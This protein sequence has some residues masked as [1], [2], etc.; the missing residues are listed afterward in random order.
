MGL[1]PPLARF[2]GRACSEITSFAVGARIASARC[3][4]DWD[5][6]E[7]VLVIVHTS[8]R[9]LEPARAEPPMLDLRDDEPT[10]RQRCEFEEDTAVELGWAS[11]G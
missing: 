8:G 3:M 10:Q 5:P 2:R 6:T 11:D 7:R 4:D 1:L 9:E